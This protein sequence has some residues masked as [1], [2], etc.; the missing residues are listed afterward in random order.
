MNDNKGRKDIQQPLLHNGCRVVTDIRSTDILKIMSEKLDGRGLP[1]STKYLFPRVVSGH[2][3]KGEMS[4]SKQ[5]F[6]TIYLLLDD[7][8]YMV[9]FSC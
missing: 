9:T 4:L 5:L 3:D 8:I 6:Y 7:V 2:M 1:E